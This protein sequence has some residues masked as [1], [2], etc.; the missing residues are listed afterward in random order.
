MKR[1]TL[2][3]LPFIRR[4]SNRPLRSAAVAL[5]ALLAPGCITVDTGAPVRSV[6]D[7]HHV[8]EVPAPPAMPAAPAP[9]AT[10]V[11]VRPFR[12]ADR[13]GKR[14][15]RREAG[16]RVELNEVLM[17]GG[18]QTRIGQPLIEGARVTATIQ[19]DASGP[20]IR[21]F[22]YKRRKRYRLTKGHRQ[23]YT[24]IK[25]DSIEA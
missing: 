6:P 23:H 17:I 16:S 12:G 19:G 25:I 8:L 5:A 4:P 7:R 3:R 15:L 10:V 11:A 14:V 18:D 9:S 2:N 24:R 1:C 21:I 22:K 13:L 20:K